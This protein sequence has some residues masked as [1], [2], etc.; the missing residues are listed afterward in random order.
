V[1]E[2]AQEPPELV[3]IADECPGRESGFLKQQQANGSF[4]AMYQGHQWLG[5]FIKPEA[6]DPTCTPTLERRTVSHILGNLIK[7]FKRL[8]AG[9]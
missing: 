3:R 9:W 5:L 6:H 8:S 1:V 4:T 7:F 2:H